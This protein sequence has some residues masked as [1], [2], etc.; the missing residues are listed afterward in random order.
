MINR[1]LA[2]ILAT[3]ILDGVGYGLAIPV[4]PG[5]LRELSHESEIAGRLGYFLAIYPLMQFLAAPVLGRLS[6]RFGRRPILLIS[7]AGAAV[8][9]A[10]MGLSPLLSVLYLGR[11]LAGITGA[12]VSVATAYVTDVSAEDDR[13]RR[14]GQMNA[15]F[16]IGFVAGPILGG[17][18]GSFSPRWP[19][20]LAALS[21]ALNLAM[22][23]FLLPESRRP[24]HAPPG[25]GSERRFASLKAMLGDRAL[26]PLFAAYTLIWLIG[27]IPNSIW[28][29]YGEDR[30]G[31]DVRMVGLSY[32]SFGLL[33][34]IAQA[35]FTGPTTRL[36]GERG[37][38]AVG[39]VADASAFVAMALVTRGWM[40]FPIMIFFTVGGIAQPALQSLLS[41]RV[42][43]DR[44]GELQGTLVGLTSLTEVIGPIVAT[45]IY[46]ASPASSRGAV[47]FV[48]A[49]LYAACFPALLKR[50]AGPAAGPADDRV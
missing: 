1:P 7:M 23:Y 27:Q 22:G 29:V 14:F 31:W 8:D 43:E 5:L 32:A 45:S 19:F 3:V 34:A 46:A 33:H 39:V 42:D 48:G 30:F 20:L 25:P 36:L 4:I 11:V 28:V 13:A 2:V 21:N 50:M 35:F 41:K 44:Q 6:D 24:G 40:V 26:L 18:L 17:V 10:V 49:G 16:G 38:I 37:A 12:N 9:Y 15:C 47:W